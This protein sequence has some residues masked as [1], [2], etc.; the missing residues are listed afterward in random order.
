MLKKI[1]LNNKG[2]LVQKDEIYFGGRYSF[3]ERLSMNGIG[4]P[5]VIYQSGIPYF[6]ALESIENELSFVNFELM[7]NGFLLRLNRNQQLRYIGFQLHEILKI[8]LK[9]SDQEVKLSIYTTAD[10]D[11]LRFRLPIIAIEKLHKYFKKAVFKDKFEW[12]NA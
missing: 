2:Q 1:I 11:I 9:K 12:G 8:E 3:L 10:M 7:K 5:K 6:D 4:S